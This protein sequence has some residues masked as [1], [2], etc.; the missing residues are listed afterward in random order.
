MRLC[1]AFALAAVVLTTA[2]L[3]SGVPIAAAHHSQA[4][5]FHMDRWVEIEGIVQRWLF[6]NPHPV[7]LSGSHR[8]EQRTRH[9]ADR[10]CP[11]D[12]SG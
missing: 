7:L 3:T 12:R 2:T 10:V 5:A 11:G 8:R 4:A 1:S 6:R 9:V